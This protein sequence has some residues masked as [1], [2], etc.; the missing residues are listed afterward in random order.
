MRY[1]LS[2]YK[3]TT[4]KPMLPNK[5]RGRVRLGRVLFLARRDDFEDLVSKWTLTRLSRSRRDVTLVR[6]LQNWAQ[7]RSVEQV[8]SRK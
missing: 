1:E 4:I 7:A 6:F 5:L 3:W 8:V 2:D